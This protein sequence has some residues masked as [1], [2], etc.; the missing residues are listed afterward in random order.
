[1]TAIIDIPMLSLVKS[2]EKNQNQK[3]Y[4]STVEHYVTI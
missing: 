3:S 4:F 1:M 2:K